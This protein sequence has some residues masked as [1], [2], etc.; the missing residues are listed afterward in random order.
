MLSNADLAALVA[1][2]HALHRQPEVSGEEMATAA[3]VRAF[4]ADTGPDAV[5]EGLGGHGL[6]LVYHGAA[7]G[8]TVLIR[9]ELDALP[10]EEIGDLPHRSQI[11]GKGHL[12]GHDGHSTILCGVARL[13][14]RA[15]PARGRVVLMFQPA[16]ETGAG[17]AAVLADPRFSDLVPDYA[18]SLHNL[19]GLPL[20]RAAIA[21]GPANCASVGMRLRFLGRTSH[22]AEPH[23]GVTPGPA[24]GRLIPALLALGQGGDLGPAFRLV[25]LTHLRMGEPAFGITPGEAEL[26]AT[27]RTMTDAGMADLRARA[28]A[29]V[30]AEAAAEGLGLEI[31]WHDDFAAC[32]NDPE[33]TALMRAALEGAGVPLIS[34]E[35]MRASEDFGRFGTVAKAAM[36]WLGSGEDHPALHNPDY[37]FPDDLVAIGTRAFD[38]VIQ[39]LLG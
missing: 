18:F 30:E 11:T 7:P 9:S 22:A 15:R 23:K 25:T 13:L 28:V 20:G 1:F 4:T 32:T 6:A 39:D 33:A 26:W 37:D 2:R 17:A 34:A 24:L 29:L 14:G 19:P 5:I 35:P 3:A 38:R 36:F 8:P 31:T 10:I 21:A 16:E 12:C 27:L